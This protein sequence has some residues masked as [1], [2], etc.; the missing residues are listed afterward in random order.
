M[1]YLRINGSQSLLFSEQERNSNSAI[2]QR[3]SE[4][5]AQLDEAKFKLREQDKTIQ[6]L[7][8]TNKRLEAESNLIREE[9]ERME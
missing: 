7:A 1:S 4:V 5:R 2:E 6:A 9:A 3:C 8:T